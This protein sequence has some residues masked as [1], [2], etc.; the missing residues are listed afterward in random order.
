MKSLPP[1][2]TPGAHYRQ[3][4]R[5]SSPEGYFISPTPGHNARRPLAEAR[6]QKP[7][8]D[9]VGPSLERCSEHL[10]LDQSTRTQKSQW[11]GG[12][13]DSSC[14]VSI[15]RFPRSFF[16]GTRLSMAFFRRFPGLII[17]FGKKRRPFVSKGP[18]GG[19]AWVNQ[20]C[21]RVRYAA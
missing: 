11:H 1:W 6:M 13:E 5:A 2:K 16:S 12:G 10:Y 9:G 7:T 19:K 4:R 8:F 15:G 21:L 18:L 17:F 3:R 14:T 20:G